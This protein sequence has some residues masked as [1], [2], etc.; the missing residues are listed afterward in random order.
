MSIKNSFDLTGKTALVTGCSSGIGLAMAVGLAEAGANIIGVSSRL[1]AVGSEVEKAVTA[2]G[3][4]FKA[5]QCD[6]GDRDS[7]YSFIEQNIYLPNYVRSIRFSLY[8]IT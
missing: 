6:L 1:A 5:Y 4:T 7:I 3:R 8:S 2:T